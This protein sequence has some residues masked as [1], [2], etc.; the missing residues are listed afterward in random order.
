M[1]M[2]REE[3]EPLMDAMLHIPCTVGDFEGYIRFRILDSIAYPG[4][5]KKF[6]FARRDQEAAWALAMAKQVQAVQ[7][8]MQELELKE[9]DLRSSSTLSTLHIVWHHVS[10]SN[11]PPSDLPLTIAHCAISKKHN[12]PCVVVRGKGRGAQPFT[13]NSRF[14]DFL[15]DIWIV[16]KIDILIKTFAKQ[17][18]EASDPNNQMAMK[19]LVD[20]FQ[21]QHAEDITHL[22]HAFYAS[23]AHVYKSTVFALQTIV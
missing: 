18:M 8:A 7:G 22:A 20:A 4:T 15:F 16:H 14:A 2:T 19:A 21:T 9:Q 17:C 23:Y 13:V 11:L 5:Y 6:L 3:E 10:E 12:I 1:M